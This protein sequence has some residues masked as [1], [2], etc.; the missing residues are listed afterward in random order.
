MQY[1]LSFKFKISTFSSDFTIEDATGKSLGY[2]RQKL[3]K[4]KE[5]VV[6]YSDESK[7]K[8]LYRIKANQWIDFS[9]SYN[10]TNHLGEKLG[11]VGRRGMRSLWRATYN[12][13]NPN[14]KELYT[15][16]EKN[17]WVKVLDGLVG[18]IPVLNFFTG[19]LFN[20]SYEVRDLQGDAFFVL[21]KMPSFFG[22]RFEL[23]QIKP[24][25]E[26][27][28]ALVIM[29]LFMMMLLERHRG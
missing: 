11:R 28:E 4:L 25:H 8:E 27:D 19:Y 5:D 21:K 13:F 12:I 17:P 23:S 7:T 24:V 6:V 26:D 22:R 16:K 14:D 1:P 29:S 18:E 2:V 20:P 10:I 15:I 3:F 9:A